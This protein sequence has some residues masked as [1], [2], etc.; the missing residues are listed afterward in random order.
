[1]IT[2]R[3]RLAVRDGT[4]TVIDL[5]DNPQL[6]CNKLEERW[7]PLLYSTTC[8]VVTHNAGFPHGRHSPIRQRFPPEVPIR[9]TE[10]RER[11]AGDKDQQGKVDY[12]GS[13]AVR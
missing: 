13:R 5:Y 3:E 11:S 10:C 9:S 7:C 6:S 8:T 12:G 2:F 1:M 4:W